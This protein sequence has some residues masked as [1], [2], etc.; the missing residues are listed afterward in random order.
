M[1]GYQKA[2]ETFKYTE[3]DLRKAFEAG[4]NY[5]EG[6]IILYPDEH[7]FI[8]SLQK[9]KEIKSIEVEYEDK[10]VFSHYSQDL[11]KIAVYKGGCKPIVIP[12]GKVKCKINY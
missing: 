11:M 12:N 4:M 10:R 5:Q 3:E 7:G 1:E 8:Q 6:G 9:P 2:K